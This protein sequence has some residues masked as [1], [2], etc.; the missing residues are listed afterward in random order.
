MHA[1]TRILV[2][3]FIGLSISPALSVEPILVEN[4]PR[5]TQT[6]RNWHL[7]EEWRAGPEGEVFVF[8]FIVDV[9]C[10]A[11]GNTYLLDFQQQ[12]TY[13]FDPGGKF[14]YVRGRKG[15]GPGETTM[16]S[17][18]LV[19][20]DRLGLMNRYPLEIVWLDSG[21]DPAGTTTPVIEGN[22]EAILGCWYGRLRHGSLLLGMTRSTYNDEGIKSEEMLVGCSLDGTIDPVYL[23]LED[24]YLQ[25]SRDDV[26]DEGSY[27]NPLAGRW[28]LDD[29]GRIWIAPERDRYLLQAVDASGQIVL[30]T[31]REFAR[32]DRPEPEIRKIRRSIEKRWESSGLPIVV[33]DHAPCIENLWIMENPWG[34]EIWIESG[35][36][37]HDL[38]PGVM[39]RYDLF[40]LE[41]I[42]THQVD[43]VGNGDPLFDRWYLVGDNRLIMVRNASSGGYDEDDPNHPR[44]NDEALQV[45]SYRIV[46]E[47]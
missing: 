5:P 28:D 25:G 43:I 16:A 45:I 22:P 11:S 13:V 26:V 10:D 4:G 6:I 39:V 14:L 9:A 21:G 44:F 32:P 35:A 2:I 19:G 47:E 33:G 17:N 42:F 8:G 27:Y 38:P 15:E 18:L 37:R 36:S 31:T 40:D 30:E 7:K 41:G 1:M 12:E 23:D 34:A 24:A 20:P 29:T 46:W 3:I